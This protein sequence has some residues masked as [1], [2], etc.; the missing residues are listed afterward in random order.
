MGAVLRREGLY[1]S[2]IGATK[3][4]FAWIMMASILHPRG[5]NLP[6]S[7]HYP[8]D[9]VTDWIAADGYN[10]YSSPR[11]RQHLALLPRRLR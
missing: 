5:S 4:R 7:A 2:H 3:V 11:P 10:W 9:D 1:S 8:G 6:A